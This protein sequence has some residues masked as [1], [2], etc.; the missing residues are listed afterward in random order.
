MIS[1]LPKLNGRDQHL[2]TLVRVRAAGVLL[3]H[4][5]PQTHL[6]WRRVAP[7]LARNFTIVCADLRG[8]GA[9]ARGTVRQMTSPECAS[10]TLASCALLKNLDDALRKSF[11]A[12]AVSA[13][14]L[15]AD[16]RQ[17]CFG[18]SA[19]QPLRQRSSFQPNSFE[20]VGGVLQHRQQ[21]FRFARPPLLP[22]RSC[23]RHPQCRCSS[24]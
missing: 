10:A 20:V 16:H 11:M 18:E 4:G 8:Y 6:M 24:P 9:H 13:P 7:L 12:A 22:E 17:S 21:R 1:K 2:R 15:N 23:L 19:E 3:L 14:R 5:F